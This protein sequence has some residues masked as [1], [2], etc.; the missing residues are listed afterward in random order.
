MWQV[1]LHRDRRFLLVAA[2]REFLIEV[3]AIGV[4]E[5]RVQAPAI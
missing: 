5:G 2:R 3:E 4:R 1:A